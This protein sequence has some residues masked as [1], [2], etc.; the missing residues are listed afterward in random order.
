MHL[1]TKMKR[2]NQK[3]L[4][5]RS[6]LT[7][8]MKDSFSKAKEMDMENKLLLQVKIRVLYMKVTGKMINT[9]VRVN[10]HNLME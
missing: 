1:K 9:M 8:P 2:M 3:K 6:S 10:I 7:V 5:K 4:L